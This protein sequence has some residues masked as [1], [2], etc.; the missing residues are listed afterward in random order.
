MEAEQAGSGLSSN[1]WSAKPQT[2]HFV[3]V[4]GVGGGSWCWYRIRTLLESAGHRVTC[5]DLA[6]AGIDRADPDTLFAFEDY[7]R[8]LV[9]FMAALPETEQVIVVGHSAG[10]LSLTEVSH[11]FPKKI[12]VAVYLAATMLKLGFC[13]HQDFLDGVPDLS[14][15]GDKVYDLRFG[16]G[17]DEPPT[18]AVIAKP[19]LRQVAYN[20]SPPE[21]VTLASMLLKPG[22]VIALQS[23]RFDSISSSSVDGV[24]R[25][26][27]KTMQDNVVSMEQ[28]EAMIRK[29]PPSR[30]FSIDAD[31]S[32]FF[33]A[34]FLLF[35]LLINVASKNGSF[36]LEI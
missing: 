17:T 5:V 18:S 1:T 3:L 31:H 29:W 26:Y 15:F 34:P 4:H 20:T 2:S 19:F 27:I 11:K 16:K 28:Q 25:V 35:G 13:T 12:R 30:V 33:S 23:A 9:E 14:R 8:P 6:S 24:E 36:G 21:D 32:P 10:G 22:P 7:N